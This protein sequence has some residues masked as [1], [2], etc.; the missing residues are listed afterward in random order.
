MLANDIVQSPR[1][2]KHVF[3]QKGGGRVYIKTVNAPLVMDNSDP[4]IKYFELIF[5][6]EFTATGIKYGHESHGAEPWQTTLFSAESVQM[7]TIYSTDETEAVTK[8]SCT[9]SCRSSTN[10][11]EGIQAKVL[12]SPSNQ[13]ETAPIA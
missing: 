4:R 2:P 12:L 7:Y 1:L 6:S 5:E 13:R 9:P 8:A 3:G 10:W 11:A